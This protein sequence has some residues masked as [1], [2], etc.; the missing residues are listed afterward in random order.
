MKLVDLA[1]YSGATVSLF[2]Y[3]SLAF[4]N[5][6][7]FP[8]LSWVDQMFGVA[9][10]HSLN[11][12]FPYSGWDFGLI[13]CIYLSLFLLCFAF[14]NR[15]LGFFKSLRS[16]VALGS[17]FMLLTEVG[18]YAT[19]PIFLNVHV[20]QA[21]AGSF[22]SGFTNLDLMTVSS[23]LLTITSIPFRSVASRIEKQRVSRK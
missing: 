8:P 11:P 23:L 16:T 13:A 12:L 7:Y 10:L 22:L 4:M 1:A 18:I 3:L 17:C 6:G 5:F 9:Y 19:Q 20:I 21:Q 15:G 2:G 14:L